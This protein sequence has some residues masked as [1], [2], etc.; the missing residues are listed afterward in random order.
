MG[1]DDSHIWYVWFKLYETQ[2]IKMRIVVFSNVS[3]ND[4]FI[5][6]C[7]RRLWSKFDPLIC[8]SDKI[9]FSKHHLNHEL[10]SISLIVFLKLCQLTIYNDF[11]MIN[12]LSLTILSSKIQSR[13]IL[14]ID[15][16]HIILRLK[17]H[18]SKREMSSTNNCIFFRNN[19]NNNCQIQYNE[20]YYLRFHQ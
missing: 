19:M 17:G 14:G 18:W 4:R 16:Y 7:C 10:L 13:Y 6:F 12:V 20:W 3:A 15:N 9:L 5:F 2:E 1:W 8:L 11:F